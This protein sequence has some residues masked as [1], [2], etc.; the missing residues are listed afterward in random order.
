MSDNAQT[1]HVI[2]EQYNFLGKFSI[3][4]TVKIR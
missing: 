4:Y 2:S 3:V 1:A